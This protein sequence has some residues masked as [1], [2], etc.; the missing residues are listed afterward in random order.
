MMHHYRSRL[1]FP[2]CSRGTV[3]VVSAYSMAKIADACDMLVSN[4]LTPLHLHS[5]TYPTHLIQVRRRE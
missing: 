1:L 2:K 3:V 4:D 5:L